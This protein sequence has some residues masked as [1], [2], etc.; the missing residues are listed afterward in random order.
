VQTIRPLL[1]DFSAGELSPKLNGRVD[2]GIYFKGAKEITNFR[3][4]TLGGVTKRPGTAFVAQVNGGT[5]AGSK[6]RIIP[7]VIDSTLRFIIEITGTATGSD[8]RIQFYCNDVLVTGTTTL[9][10][11]GGNLAYLATELYE[12]Q[13]AQSYR[14]IYLV[15][16]LHPPIFIRYV[17]GTVTVGVV[18]A[19]VFEYDDDLDTFSA[20]LIMWTAPT[21]TPYELYDFWDKVATWLMPRK[22]YPCIVSTFS[23]KT[24]TYCER[25]DNIIILTLATSQ[26]SNV[27]VVSGNTEI[28]GLTTTADW[29]KGFYVSG[30][31]IPTGTYIVSN[32]STTAVLSAAPTGS[33]DTTTIT[34]GNLRLAREST[35]L[36]QGTL[37]IDIRPFIGAGN[38]PSVVAYFAG[39]VWMGGSV[40]DPSTLWG[41]KVNDLMNFCVFEEIVYDTQVKTD[42]GVRLFGTDDGSPGATASLTS[43]EVTGFSGLTTNELAGKFVTGLNI[44][45]GTKVVSN[46]ATTVTLSM[47]PLAIGTC[48]MQFTAWKDAG[49][50]EYE[51]GTETTQQVGPGSAIR[52]KLATEEDETIRWI[53]GKDNLMIGT[54]SSEWVIENANNALQV[55]ATMVSRYGS[56]FIQARFVGS[57]LLYVSS[58][59]KNIRQIASDLQPPL[60]AQAEH[61]I[62]GGVTQIDFQ[63]APNVC[64]YAVLVNGEIARC[65]F[66]QSLGVMAWD[67]IRLRTGDKV[68]SIAVMP[69]S[70]MDKVYIVTERTINSVVTRNIEYFKENDD[71]LSTTR[72]YLDLAV[73]KSASAFTTVSGLTHLASQAC[74][75]LAYVTQKTVAGVVVAA[76]WHL[77]TTTPSAGGV[78]TV[79]EATYAI[80][81]LG[82]SSR[83]KTMR[84]DN[85]GSEGLQKQ[86]GN[87]FFRLKDSASFDVSWGALAVQGT[88]AI[89]PG[90]DPTY[91]GPLQITTDAASTYDAE[92]I[93]D[94]NDPVPCGIQTIV[95]VIEVG[96]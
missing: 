64:L 44:A 8:C 76:H 96:E 23:G 37:Y 94:S 80:V 34:L 30:T 21:T 9:P 57:A 39:R 60:T 18:T 25:R 90:T 28:H 24:A 43:Y 88:D 92:L 81:G 11:S 48:Y 38:Y 95:P 54:S 6:A 47:Y 51:A 82:Y 87:V 26:M 72:W 89:I 73:Q 27:H 75:Y 58:S 84:I 33:S 86:I 45:Y 74:T 91:S 63:Q 68:L 13:Y 83:L 10:L 62:S 85:A 53:A 36:H 32:T 5:T 2:L 78:A 12:I 22:A 3:V 7:W 31:N 52:I 20:N 93:I 59:A 69:G 66:D 55:R 19:A 49:V 42:Q 77:D 1:T 41:S 71:L 4:Q 35:Y 29:L 40:N 17:S 16:P 67:R 79:E 70:D 56:A 61:M 14:E 46:T 15:H 65:V 50:A